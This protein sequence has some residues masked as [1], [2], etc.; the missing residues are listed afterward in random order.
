MKSIKCD[1]CMVFIFIILCLLSFEFI[2]PPAL[3]KLEERLVKRIE[4][5]EMTKFSK[6][7]EP[8]EQEK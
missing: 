4:A 8:L 1:I 7:K 2:R 3:Y 6:S 5:L